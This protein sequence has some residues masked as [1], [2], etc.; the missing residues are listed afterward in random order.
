MSDAFSPD[1]PQEYCQVPLLQKT[2]YYLH[3][4][5]RGGQNEFLHP[6]LYNLG[7]LTTDGYMKDP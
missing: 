7:R 2:A 5:C 1:V 6:T 3:V 4:L